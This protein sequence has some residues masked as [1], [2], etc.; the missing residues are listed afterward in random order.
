MLQTKPDET[1]HWEVHVEI[2]IQC[3]FFFTIAIDEGFVIQNVVAI[4][5]AEPDRVE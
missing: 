3:Q 4:S 2:Q 1:D 5:L